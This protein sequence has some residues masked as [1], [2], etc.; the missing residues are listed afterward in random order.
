MVVRYTCLMTLT[1]TPHSDLLAVE[2][3]T[4][5][6]AWNGADEHDFVCQC[7]PYATPH[8]GAHHFLPRKHPGPLA[9]ADEVTPRFVDVNRVRVGE[10]LT[11]LQR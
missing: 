8:G 1:Y 5:V 10:A 4:R 11:L 7:D 6:A 2:S 9:L 3:T